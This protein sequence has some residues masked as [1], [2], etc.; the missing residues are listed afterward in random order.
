MDNKRIVIYGGGTVSHVR[1]HL[2][3]SA[4]AYGSTAKIIAALSPYMLPKMDVD[5]RLTKMAGGDKLETNEDI[6]K[7]LDEVITDDRTKVIIM[8]AALCDFTGT[9]RDFNDWSYPPGKTGYRIQTKNFMGG[10]IELMT[11]AKVLNKIRKQRKDIFLV[12][13]KT[14]SGAT[15]DEQYVAGLDLCKRASCNLVFANDVTNRMNMIVTPEEA[16]Y[17]VSSIR[18]YT[19]RNLM[20]MIFHRTH[21]TFTR[22]TVVAGEPIKWDSNEI[23]DTLRR[24]VNYC[25]ENNAYKPFNGV[26]AGHF[27]YKVNDNTFL[28]SIRKTNFNKLPEVGLVKIVTDGPDTVLAYGAKPSVGGQSQRIV[29]HDHPGLD[30]IVHF[31]CHKKDTSEVPTVSQREFECGS[32]EC[33][34]NTSKGLKQFGNIHA[35]FLDNHGPN[36]VFNSKINPQ[37]VINFIEANFDLSTKTGGFVSIKS[38]L[39]TSATHE[40]ALDILTK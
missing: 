33:G 38:R 35:V 31:H 34:Q 21:L 27:A 29:F 11:A 16:R 22:S 20:Q 12:G 14:T 5:L 40:T 36:I 15:Q 24:V 23:P 8:S 3:L 37:E 19:I 4:P 1:P 13:F 7:D 2:A 26:T 6:A 28:T 9:Y 32:H 39:E 17:A 10:S 25:I 18:G 30:C